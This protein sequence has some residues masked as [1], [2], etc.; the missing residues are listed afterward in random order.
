MKRIT[1]IAFAILAGTF[2]AA[3]AVQA[4]QWLFD[5]QYLV[6]GLGYEDK[7][8]DQDKYNG[9]KL[10]AEGRYILNKKEEPVDEKRQCCEIP[11]TPTEYRGVLDAALRYGFESKELEYVGL[12]V[13]P[14]ARMWDPSQES[15]DA[16]QARRDLLE[17]GVT[18]YVSD[19]A[20]ELDSYLEVSF[21]RAGRVGEYKP[22]PQ[23]AWAFDLG[24]QASVGYA[25]AESTDKD[26]SK[27]NNPYAGIYLDAAVNHDRF[28]SIY[29]Q[30][31]FVNGFSLS[32]PSRG[33]PT[34]RE[35]RVRNG[36]AKGLGEN[37]G[38]DVYWEKRSFY[39]DEGGLPG[40]YSW[41]RTYGAELSWSF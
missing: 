14:W 38:L 31:R 35:A 28:G 23:S 30:G 16:W 6:G 15:D 2:A 18:R 8:P 22:S 41:V 20:L 1:S 39:F 25:W 17:L 27:V 19:D 7:M 13:T 36:Y 33:N 12:G 4:E 24:A 26:Y 3:P 11:S 40:L 9:T 37:F 34:A 29:F 10:I 5:D 32:N 21:F